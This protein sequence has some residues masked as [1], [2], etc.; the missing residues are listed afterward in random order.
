MPFHAAHR[1][2]RS[3]APTCLLYL[4]ITCPCH[5]VHRRS[6]PSFFHVEAEG[7][8]ILRRQ[9]ELQLYSATLRCFILTA[10]LMYIPQLRRLHKEAY[11]M[12][13]SS[14]RAQAPRVRLW[15][16]Q[17]YLLDL[18]GREGIINPSG[19]FITLGLAISTA[20]LLGLHQDCGSWSIPGWEK[21]LRTRLWW[22]LLNY[23]RL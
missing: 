9:V 22:S 7:H 19:S 6:L 2:L 17:V 15:T 16:L 8:P 1:G 11:N 5:R 14:L 21:E 13:M 20:L 3:R 10:G 18:D 12:C 23:D 4:P